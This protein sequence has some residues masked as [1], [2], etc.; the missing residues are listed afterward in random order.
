MPMSTV[1][2]IRAMQAGMKGL[3]IGGSEPRPQ[4]YTP[5]G[6]LD[7]AIQQD[8]NAAYP[9]PA[10]QP[11]QPILP[12]DA[13]LNAEIVQNPYGGDFDRASAGKGFQPKK[14][15]TYGQRRG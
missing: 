13:A 11:P 10:Y 5:Y 9:T 2:R 15:P 3:D 7:A 12:P 6:G 8:F 14:K 4:P 1:D